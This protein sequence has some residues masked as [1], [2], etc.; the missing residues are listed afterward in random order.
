[1][2]RVFVLCISL[3]LCA[4]APLKVLPLARLPLAGG[5]A[6]DRPRQGERHIVVYPFDD[7]RG[8][9]FA[10]FSASNSIPL[11]NLFH[12]GVRCDYPEQSAFSMADGSAVTVGT[13]DQALPS[14]LAATMRQMRLTPNASAAGELPVATRTRADYLVTGRLRR[15]R[16]ESSE[17]PLL[18]A[19]L[20]LLGV[21]HRVDRFELEFEITLFKGENTGL[22][23]MRRTYHFSD[24]QVVGLYYHLEARHTLLV[25][26][27]E[28]TLPKAVDDLALAMR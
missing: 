7:D 20:G 23:L 17:S 9:E 10:R 12:N 18:G 21:P 24:A 19:T 14:L 22:P 1:M 28:Q 15:S 27:L 16:Y 6:L 5:S 4:C 25:R 26:A 8:D 13:L 2:R 3:A 11:V